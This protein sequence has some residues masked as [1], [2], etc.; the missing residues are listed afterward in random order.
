M[1]EAS[2]DLTLGQVRRKLQFKKSKQVAS[3]VSGIGIA[4]KL[5]FAVTLLRIVLTI[6]MYRTGKLTIDCAKGVLRIGN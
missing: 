1:R 4:H 3:I 2:G 6:G 5:S